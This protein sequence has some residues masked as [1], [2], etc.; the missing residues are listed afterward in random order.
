MVSK[1]SSSV[2]RAIQFEAEKAGAEECCGILLGTEDQIIAALPVR[3]VHPTPETHF[4]IDPAALIAAYREE[5]GGGP[6]VHGFYHSHPDGPA[7]PSVTD[8]ALAPGDG[9]LWA[10]VAAGEITWWRDAAEGFTPLSL[11]VFDG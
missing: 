5:R 8:R 11:S 4:E 3:N 7:H 1:V 6:K 9:K 10:I 2:L